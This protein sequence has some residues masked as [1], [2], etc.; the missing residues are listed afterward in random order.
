MT[1]PDISSVSYEEAQVRVEELRRAIEHH[2]YRYYVLDDPEITDAEYDTLFRELQAF[3]AAFPDLDSPE[4]PTKRVGGAVAD[5]F[6]TYVH[7][8]PMLSLDN[9]M[10][11]EQWDDFHRRVLGGISQDN[12]EYWVDPK[13]DGLALEVIYENGRFVRAAT[14]GDGEKGEDV[15]ENMRTVDN[16]PLRLRDA[17]P[18]PE[19]LEVRGEVVIGVAGFAD[20]NR[21]QAARGGKIFANPRNAAA[22]S[23]R[24]LDPKIAASR[25][26]RFIAYGLGRVQWKTGGDLLS[27]PPQWRTQQ[28]AMYG[29]RELGFTIAPEAGLCRSSEEVKAKFRVLQEKRDSLPFEIDGMVAKVNKIALQQALKETAR[30]PKWAL[31]LKF[32]AQQKETVLEDISIQVGRTGVLTPVAHLA[33]VQVGGVEVS[34][35]TLHNQDEIAAK[36]FRIGDTVIVQRAGDVIPQLVGVILEKRPEDAVPYLFPEICPECG[37]SVFRQEDEAAV[38]CTNTFCPAML[39]RGMSHFVS[40]AGLDMQGVGQKWVEKLVDE[41]IVTSPVDLFTLR[42]SDLLQF[43][44]MGAKSAE[45]FIQAVGTAKKGAML[46]R[47]IG[48]LGIRHV[49]EQTARTLAANF[50]DLDG[51]AAATR[52]TLTGLPDVGPEVAG[53]IRSFFQQE[54]TKELLTRFKEIDLWPLQEKVDEAEAGA[55]PLAGK[56]FIFTGSL[57]VGRKEAEALVEK[58]GGNCMKSIS[59]KLDYVVA[60]EKAGSKL[61]KAEKL[62]LTVLDYEEFLSLVEPHIGKE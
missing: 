13:M 49:G 36:D 24:Q 46:H 41:G 4:S 30:A 37:S 29:L 8:L 15:T 57:P 21:R 59:A 23:I 6:E 25:P 39:R 34:R 16:L 56:K 58:L 3:E 20:L 43:E 62:G 33:P 60:G 22:G 9:A 27:M 44:R 53:A 38:R 19:V 5:G 54:S 1:L 2:S 61:A 45:K 17:G 48:A 7:A 12:C 35:A 28:E 14:R 51:L 18:V 11:E 55:L 26:L 40:K 52:E 42:V 32:P 31:A 47:L 50:A 10:N